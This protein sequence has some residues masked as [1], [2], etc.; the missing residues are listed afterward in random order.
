M[1]NRSI[2]SIAVAILLAVAVSASAD[3]P[4]YPRFR[5]VNRTPYQLVG[6]F[7]V[8][9]NINDLNRSIVLTPLEV[10]LAPGAAAERLLPYR[11]SHNIDSSPSIQGVTPQ[12]CTFKLNGADITWNQGYTCSTTG[13]QNFSVYNG[14]T[15]RLS[16]SKGS[17]NVAEQDYA[18]IYID[19]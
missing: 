6:T 11:I 7:Q 8:S 1:G 3:P 5:V 12:F 15:V 13:T 2:R 9:Y 18:D 4:P 19:W 16:L 17:W 14:K 10:N